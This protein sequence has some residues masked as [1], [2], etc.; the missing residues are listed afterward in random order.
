MTKFPKKEEMVRQLQAWGVPFPENISWND[1]KKLYWDAKKLKDEPEGFS[2]VPVSHRPFSSSLRR[3]W[4]ARRTLRPFVAFWS[5]R[6]LLRASPHGIRPPSRPL[7]PTDC[8][9]FSDLLTCRPARRRGDPGFALAGKLASS[10]LPTRRAPHERT[11][12]QCRSHV[13]Y[14]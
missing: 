4:S 14:W 12:G 3:Y 5:A 2:F 6:R 1:L 9:P 13:G 8:S 11:V 7:Q 10:H